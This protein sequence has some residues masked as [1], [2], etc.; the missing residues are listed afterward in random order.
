MAFSALLEL[1]AVCRH[2]TAGETTV[3]AL[4]NVSLSIGRGEFVAIMGQSGSGKSTLMNILGCLD[5]PS[6]GRYSV[7]GHDVSQLSVAQLSALRLKTFGFVFQRYQ[8]LA[9][10]TAVENVAM[11]AVYSGGAR[12]ERSARAE[13]LLQQLGLGDR[14]HHKPAQLS[15][16]QQQRVSIARALINGAEVILADE[17]T[18]ALDSAS[19]EQVLSLLTQLNRESGTTVI[20]ITHDAQVAAQ[21]DR[22][23]QMKD[24]EIISDSHAHA[25]SQPIHKQQTPAALGVFPRISLLESLRLAL[26]SLQANWFRTLLTLLG[27]IIGVA[28]VVTMMAI[29]EGGKQQVLQRIESMGTNILQVR[30]GGRNIRASGNIA[31]LTME[32]AAALA[33]LPGV[34]AVSPERDDRATLRHGSSDYSGRVRGVA[35]SYFGIRNWELAQGVLLD[36]NDLSSYASVM[37]MGATVA[38]QLFPNSSYPIGEYVLMN[39]AFY[40]V[41]GVLKAKGGGGGW[42]MDDEVYIPITTAQL[43]LFGREFLSG[44]LLK[45]E[46]T[47]LLPAVEAAATEE[48]K[49]RHGREDFMV[50]NTAS[51]VEAVSATQ[52]TLTLMLGSVAAI[53]LFVGGI[54][55]M[56]IMLVNV[57]ERRREIGLRIATGAKPADILRQFNIEALVV[58]LLGGAIGV[59][60]GLGISLVLQQ[61]NVAVAFSLAPPLLAFTTSLLVGV[62]FGYAPAHKAASLNPIQA[63][64]EE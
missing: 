56:N 58:C 4:H 6:A 41:I 31:T 52:D 36:E 51:L 40:Q 57:S 32:D 49:R 50:R 2:F 60:L 27:I 35:P 61:A 42:D 29:G 12:A 1:Q 18:G 19:G 54:G 64:A 59:A 5:T 38:E 26:G 45:V 13:Q 11:P 24:G 53:S 20:L 44:I 55:V 22:V 21:A 30:P 62:I 8:L 14:M 48:L 7:G 16:G 46:D 43:K 9:N 25:S 17:P 15:G 37:V 10:H 28:S 34:A 23:V 39:N 3:R 33:A 63:L 47:D